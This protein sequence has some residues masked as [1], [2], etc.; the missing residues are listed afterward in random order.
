IGITT[1]PF[2]CSPRVTPCPP[3]LAL[4]TCPCS[5]F[6][7]FI[8]RRSWRR[9]TADGSPRTAASCCSARWSG[10]SG[11]R[12]TRVR[13]KA[14]EIQLVIV[15]CNFETVGLA[16]KCRLDLD[17]FKS[18]H[19]KDLQQCVERRLQPEP[20]AHDRNQHIDRNGDPDLRLHGVLRRAIE[21]FDPQV[22]FAGECR[23]LGYF[24]PADRLRS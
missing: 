3:P 24:S 6:R 21:P 23:V 16:R 18:R 22:L 14:Q 4:Q 1:L 7:P 9:S 12:I 15:L 5:A 20:F 10:N 2:P 8:A 11:S 17:L 19:R 13:L